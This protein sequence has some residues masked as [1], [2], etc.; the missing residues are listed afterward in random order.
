MRTRKRARFG[1]ELVAQENALAGQ[2]AEQREALAAVQASRRT[3]PT[4][5]SRCRG[6]Q[7]ARGADAVLR[8]H[9]CAALLERPDLAGLGPVTSSF[10]W[11]WERMHEGIDIAADRHL[12]VAASGQVIY[13]GWMGGY[14]N[15]VL[16]DHGGGLATAYG[17][18]PGF[19]VRQ[20]PV[21]RAGAGGRVRRL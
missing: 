4:R 16:I 19:A 17:H 14:G 6:E 7:P 3:T 9:A 21:G 2:L 15:L 13:A 20:R 1:N 8:D 12:V 18:N 10:G 5:S 11:R